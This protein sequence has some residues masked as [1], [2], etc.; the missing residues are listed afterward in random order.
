MSPDMA[1]PSASAISATATTGVHVI[2]LS[3]YSYAK[4]FLGTGE[5]VESAVFEVAGH[6]WLV[7]VF[8]NGTGDGEERAPSS[9]ALFLMLDSV[10]EDDVV[11]A[12]FQ[13]SLVRHGRKLT[14]EVLRDAVIE[15]P[16]TFNGDM[17]SGYENAVGDRGELDDPEYLKDDTILIRCDITVLNDPAVERRHLEAL[18]LL[19]DCND[20]LCEKFHLHDSNNNM[21]KKKKPSQT[22]AAM[23]PSASTIAVTAS[24]GCHV[25]KVSGYS[26]TKL[27]PGNGKHIKSPEFREAGHMWRILCFPDGDRKETA[28]HVALYLELADAECTDVHSELPVQPGAARPADKGAARWQ[29]QQRPQD[30]REQ[31]RGQLLRL[32]GFHGE[33]RA[34]EVRVPQGRLL[35]HPV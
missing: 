5:C 26:Q 17:A 24:A 1:L 32:Q 3:G 28:G 34:G 8:P 25:L 18:E 22:P 30:L 4:Q 21:K 11:H 15:A 29:D 31:V 23:L 10:S 13:F 27:L 7:K 14:A 12:D 33:G 20:G 16:A 6:S 9:I 35:V 19:C 2:K